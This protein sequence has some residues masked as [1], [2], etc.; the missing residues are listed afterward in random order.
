MVEHKFNN[1]VIFRVYHDR[2]RCETV[3]TNGKVVPAIPKPGIDEDFAKE[4]GYDNIWDLNWQHEFIHSYLADQKGLKESY[5]LK[6]VSEGGTEPNEDTGK[7]EYEVITIQKKLNSG[8]GF[9][10]LKTLLKSLK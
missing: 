8:E 7:E 5:V 10:E 1:G 6:Y 2:Q 3:L 9:S 4:C